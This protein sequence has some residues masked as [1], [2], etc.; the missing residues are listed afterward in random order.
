MTFLKNN[1]ELI[2]SLSEIKRQYNFI[3]EKILEDDACIDIYKEV[4]SLEMKVKMIRNEILFHHIEHC[5]KAFMDVREE[6]K[7]FC[8]EITEFLRFI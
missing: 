7:A 1:E 3:Y 6:Y 4:I 2:Y 8:D 5:N